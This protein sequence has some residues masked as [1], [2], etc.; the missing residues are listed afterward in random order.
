VRQYLPLFGAWRPKAKQRAIIY[1]TA[2]YTAL[3][4]Q[5]DLYAPP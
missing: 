4:E 5:N 3:K 2:S 1:S